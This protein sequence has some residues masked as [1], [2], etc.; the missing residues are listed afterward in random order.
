M[1]LYI[2]LSRVIMNGWGVYTTWCVVASLVNLTHA[3]V[4]DGDVDMK[5]VTMVDMKG[6]KMVDK[7]SHKCRYKGSQI[8]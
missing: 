7:G 8:G 6:V 2:Y 3:L 4:Y 5:V 1:Y